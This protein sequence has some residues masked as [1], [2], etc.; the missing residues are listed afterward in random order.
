MNILKSNNLRREINPSMVLVLGFL[1][2]IFLGAILLNLP[3]ASN[4]NQS[5]GFINALFTSTSAVCV[6]GLIVVNTSLHWTLFGKIVIMLLIQIGGLGF[7][8]ITTLIVVAMGKKIGLKNRMLIQEDLGQHS[9]S[10]VVRISL[11]IVKVTFLIEFI[12]AI[13][14]AT[15][16]VPEFGTKTGIFY[17]IFHSISAFCNAGFD[18]I[19]NSLENYVTSPVINFTI[20]G[21]IVLG[22]IGFTV[23]LDVYRSKNIRRL[24]LHT[25]IVLLITGILL[26][27]GLVF[28]FM[29]E[30]NNVNTIGDLSLPNK[31]MASSFQSVTPRTAG[32][33]TVPTGQLNDTSKF[34]TIVYMFIGGSPGSTAGGIKTATLGVLLLAVYSEIIGKDQINF[35]KRRIDYETVSRCISILFIALALVIFVTII[36]SITEVQNFLD[37]FFET[38]SAFGTV[39]LS[40]GITGELSAIGKVIVSITMFMGRVGPITVATAIA[41]RH[42]GKKDRIKYPKEK[43]IVG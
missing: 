12:G 39:G 33:N 31:I 11:K 30:Y 38:V 3:V 40:T 7:M 2:V 23:M 6:T 32:F 13:L 20:M 26:V 9:I 29:L 10:G 15:K 41:S 8:T 17:G 36:L 43:I 37:I 27:S 34:L 24:N 19:G 28:F 35:A 22:G 42:T 14:L 4:N 1:G 25:K 16:F 5:V 21:L 18:L